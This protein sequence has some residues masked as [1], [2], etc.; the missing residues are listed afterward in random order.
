MISTTVGDQPTRTASVKV[1]AERGN[2]LRRRA[3]RSTDAGE[4]TE[5]EVPFTDDDALA[6]EVSGYG[7]DVVVLAP[8]EVRDLVVGRLRG[9]LAAHAGGVA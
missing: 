5:L 6:D 1:R 8:P 7:A 4:W 3:T 2:S 9:A